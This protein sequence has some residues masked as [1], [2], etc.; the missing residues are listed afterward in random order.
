MVFPGIAGWRGLL[1]NAW[2]LSK[3]WFPCSN[4]ETKDLHDM[5]LYRLR[6]DR[7]RQSCGALIGTESVWALLEISVVLSGEC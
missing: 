5:H 4:S 6:R 1:P 3:A 7:L 2:N